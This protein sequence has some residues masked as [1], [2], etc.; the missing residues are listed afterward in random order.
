MKVK[1]YVIKSVFILCL[2][3]ITILPLFSVIFTLDSNAIRYIFNDNKFINSI[4][5]S[6]VYSSISSIICVALAL[7]C[8]MMLLQLPK[9]LRPKLAFALTMPLLVPSLSIGL[10]L[11]FMV[12][13]NGMLDKIFGLQDTTLG[14]GTLIVCSVVCLFPTAFII[15]Y[16]AIQYDSKQKYIVAD[17]SGVSK[18]SQFIRLTIPSIKT[19]IVYAFIVAFTVIFSDYGIPMETAGMIRTLPMYLYETMQSSFDYIRAAVCI[20][21]LLCPAILSIISNAKVNVGTIEANNTVED[22]QRHS[23]IYTIALTIVSIVLFIPQLSFM[24]VAFVDNFPNGMSFTIVNFIAAFNRSYGPS[25]TEYILNS[26]LLALLTAIIGTTFCFILAYSS[27][28]LR[29]KLST[30]IDSL[31]TIMLSIPGL[32]IGVC[33]VFTFAKTK[34]VFYNT[35]AILVV[36]NIAHMIGSPYLLAKN[37]LLKINSNY[38]LIG[39]SLGIKPVSILFKVILPNASK[40]IVAMFSYF[41]VNSLT[42]VTAVLFLC[43]YANQPLSVLITVYDKS[44]NYEM[45]AVISTILFVISITAKLIF[46]KIEK[47]IERKV[48]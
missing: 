33:Y 6:I 27:T 14:F 38:E 9:K 44:L 48:L 39:S 46:I 20:L 34:G 22:K 28:R 31:S 45:Q 36:A 15:L 12:G 18:V 32:V 19:S 16:D 29:D 1:R 10:G 25:I 2:L 43:T 3:S 5:N 41:F 24:I 30:V 26:I 4:V 21:L 17:L 40:T 8:A 47:Q 37:A 11:K 35:I 7:T 23:C 13:K 42:T